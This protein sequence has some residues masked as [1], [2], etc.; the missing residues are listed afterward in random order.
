MKRFD[1]YDYLPLNAES[2]GEQEDPTDAARGIGIGL[3]W[4]I[5]VW[6]AI[7]LI[8]LYWRLAK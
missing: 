6:G 2:R 1:N 3:I 8:V 5:I 7:G 4:G